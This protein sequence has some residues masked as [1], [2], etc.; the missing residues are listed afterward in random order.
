MHV[1]KDGLK[2]FDSFFT[3]TKSLF[4]IKI[5]SPLQE[6]LTDVAASG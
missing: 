3:T 2:V 6:A 1:D 4:S 5:I